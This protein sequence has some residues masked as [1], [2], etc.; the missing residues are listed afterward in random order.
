MNSTLRTIL[1]ATAAAV[2][3]VI[4][5][6]QISGYL[7]QR[8]QIAAQRQ[9]IQKTV[10]ENTVAVNDLLEFEIKTNSATYAE[11][12][13]R[14]D[15]RLKKLAD[16][17]IP[18]G[19][20]LL[21]DDEKASVKAYL[22]GLQQLVRLEAAVYR[23]SLAADAA[24]DTAKDAVHE[25]S[26]A[27]YYSRDYVRKRAVDA[28]ADSDK[29][30]HELEAAHREFVANLTSFRKSLA[31]LRNTLNEYKLLDDAFLGSVIQKSAKD[32]NGA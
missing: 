32:A 5:Y 2:V 1:I 10:A 6:S 26:T 16:A 21:P 7:E 15:D 31:T 20:S 12:F 22:E 4:A 24:F 29:D 19:T 18:V 17:T 3:A 9:D 11:L 25:M 23:K 8:R 27:D 30:L 14:S 28:L 13:E